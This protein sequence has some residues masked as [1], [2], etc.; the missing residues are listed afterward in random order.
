MNNKA[1][2]R[3]SVVRFFSF[4]LLLF[5]FLLTIIVISLFSLALADNIINNYN[6]HHNSI[7]VFNKQCIKLLNKIKHG[8]PVSKPDFQILENKCKSNHHHIVNVTL[9]LLRQVFMGFAHN[10]GNLVK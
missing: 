3:S 6:H 5:L 1:T 9:D 10:P 4:I 7:G 8:I 2:S